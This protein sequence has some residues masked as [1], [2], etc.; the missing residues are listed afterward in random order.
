M[1]FIVKGTPGHTV[2][3]ADTGLFRGGGDRHEI[4]IICTLLKLKNVNIRVLGPVG[5]GGMGSPP[6]MNTPLHCKLSQ[7]TGNHLATCISGELAE[8]SWNPN[9]FPLGA[10][11]ARQI[12]GTR[13]RV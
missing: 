5:M 8:I 11:C 10:F 3:G 12:K 1:A 2:S 7:C 13:Y 6:P 9:G 4:A